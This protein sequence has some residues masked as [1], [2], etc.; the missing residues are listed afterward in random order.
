MTWKN[1]LDELTARAALATGPEKS[2]WIA[3]VREYMHSLPPNRIIEE[4]TQIR[5][6]LQLRILISAGIPGGAWQRVMEHI[7]EVERELATRLRE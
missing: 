5:N 4:A 6:P 3:R 1:R 2:A 7:A